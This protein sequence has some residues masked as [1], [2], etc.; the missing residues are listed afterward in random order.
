MPIVQLL[1]Y[2]TAVAKGLDPDKPKNLTQV[3]VLNSDTS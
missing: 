2:Y 3:V 1:G